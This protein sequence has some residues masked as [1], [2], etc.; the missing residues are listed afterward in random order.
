[1]YKFN[2]QKVLTLSF[3]F[4]QHDEIF[5]VQRYIRNRQGSITEINTETVKS[6]FLARSDNY[7]QLSSKWLPI[8]KANKYNK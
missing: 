6:Y 8:L 5:I 3:P 2:K 4:A 7:G 1:M